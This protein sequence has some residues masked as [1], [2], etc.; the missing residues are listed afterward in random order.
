M[1]LELTQG[2]LRLGRFLCHTTVCMGVQKHTF[3]RSRCP[4]MLVRMAAPVWKVSSSTCL[5][6]RTC[7][8]AWA[9]S[10]RPDCQ[11]PFPLGPVRSRSCALSASSMRFLMSRSS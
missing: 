4:A 1:S 2:R 7:P 10:S 6:L 3:R 11:D 5:L 8:M 9:S